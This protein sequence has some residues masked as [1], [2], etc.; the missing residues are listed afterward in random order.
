MVERRAYML[1]E[2]LYGSGDPLRLERLDA[3]VAAEGTVAA[4]QS[5]ARRPAGHAAGQ[6]VAPGAA[7]LA[8]RGAR[9]RRVSAPERPLI[10]RKQDFF[11]LQFRLN[12]SMC[13]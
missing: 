8:F 5:G 9:R 2:R 10:V 6:R 1:P 11:L 7:E 4:A 12:R 13:L 3:G